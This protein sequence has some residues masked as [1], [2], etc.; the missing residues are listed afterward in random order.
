MPRELA[1]ADTI[2]QIKQ[3]LNELERS[4]E[5]KVNK[6]TKED[7]DAALVMGTHNHLRGD[8]LTEYAITVA[9]NLNSPNLLFKKQDAVKYLI[10]DT[11][12]R[13]QRYE[14]G[15]KT[16]PFIGYEERHKNNIKILNKHREYG[17]LMTRVIRMIKFIA[18][19][20][21]NAT[22]RRKNPYKV[23][24]PFR[25]ANSGRQAQKIQNKINNLLQPK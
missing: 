15:A 2:S 14:N 6:L 8:K 21:I 25:D 12:E 19:K 18:V 23:F 17:H 20:G 13:L 5:H 16:C 7:Y 24:S 9:R 22:Y 10:K 11:K 4:I 3:I 1:I